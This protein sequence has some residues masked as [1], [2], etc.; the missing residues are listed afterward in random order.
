MIVGAGAGNDSG[1]GVDPPAPVTTRIASSAACIDPFLRSFPSLSSPE[2]AV[3]EIGVAGVERSEPSETRRPGGSLRSPPTTSHEEDRPGT[4][5]GSIPI[6]MAITFLPNWSF[7][8]SK[9]QTSAGSP[10]GGGPLKNP[11]RTCYTLNGWLISPLGRQGPYHAP[12]L[13]EELRCQAFNPVS[14]VA[15]GAR[16][17]GKEPEAEGEAA[18]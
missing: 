15:M 1:A 18:G 6:P 14:H 4:D 11:T 17:P 2:L 12:D 8:R 3:P 9:V 5:D 10:N 7:T 16:N 13:A